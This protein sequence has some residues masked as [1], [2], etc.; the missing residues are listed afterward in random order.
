MH[1]TVSP[2]AVGFTVPIAFEQYPLKRSTHWRR[3]ALCGTRVLDLDSFCSAFRD[4][5]AI[6]RINDLDVLRAFSACLGAQ[7]VATLLGQS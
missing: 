6:P 1:E 4:P 7:N 2:K 5:D 3:R